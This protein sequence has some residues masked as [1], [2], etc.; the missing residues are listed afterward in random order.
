RCSSDESGSIRGARRLNEGGRMK[1]LL[2]TVFTFH[3]LFSLLTDILPLLVYAITGNTSS[4]G[5]VLATFMFALL[6]A[7]VYLLKYDVEEVRL[8]KVGLLLY[9]S[10]FGLLL[11]GSTTLFVFFISA[12]LFGIAVGI[13]APA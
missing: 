10:G 6:G 8:L 5:Y 7:R 13:I 12:L 2:Y 3:F 9:S 1:T 11:I 4:S